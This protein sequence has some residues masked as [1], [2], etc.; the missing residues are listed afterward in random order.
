VL[1]SRLQC[2]LTTCWLEKAAAAGAAAAAMFTT[3]C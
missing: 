1:S 3:P 2:R